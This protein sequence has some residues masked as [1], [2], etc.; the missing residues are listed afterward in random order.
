MRG[1]GRGWGS[2]RCTNSS[3]DREKRRWTEVV[4]LHGHL[5]SLSLQ[6]R[7]VYQGIRM[8]PCF[9]LPDDAGRAY[10]FQWRAQSLKDKMCRSLLIPTTARWN[11]IQWIKSSWPNICES[12]LMTVNLIRMVFPTDEYIATPRLLTITRANGCG[13]PRTQRYND[14]HHIGLQ[15]NAWTWLAAFHRS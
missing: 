7:I 3:T 14:T 10:E 2:D 12:L 8:S 13:L 4:V 15:K 11:G 9:R 5:L 6:E 1:V